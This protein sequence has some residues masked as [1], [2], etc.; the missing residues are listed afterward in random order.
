MH[1]ENTSASNKKKADWS[2][3]TDPYNKV[4]P[5]VTH[6]KNNTTLVREVRRTLANTDSSANVSFEI[7]P[8]IH[9]AGT[10]LTSVSSATHFIP[11]KNQEGSTW[12]SGNA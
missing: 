7:R 9:R 1:E 6:R 11:L 4:R 2:E 3:E 5:R 10:S 8:V 12:K